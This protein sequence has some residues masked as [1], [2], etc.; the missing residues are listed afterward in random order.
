MTYQI[1]GLLKMAEVDDFE[2]GCLSEGAYD[3]HVDVRFSGQTVNEVI[4][5][6]AA[7]IGV[8]SDAIERNACDEMGRVDFASTEDDSG[9]QLSAGEIARWKA[10]QFRAWY[11]VYTGIVEEVRAVAA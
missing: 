2:Q 9:C 3:C 8:E 10:G 6:A 11:C 7:F 1:N 5:K 4:A